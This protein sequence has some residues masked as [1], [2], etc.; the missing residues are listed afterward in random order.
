MTTQQ[1]IKCPKFSGKQEQWG[2]FSKAF[3]DC[4]EKHDLENNARSIE[5]REMNMTYTCMALLR[6]IDGQ[7]I[8]PP[9][10]PVGNSATGNAAQKAAWK[11][12][13]IN[14]HDYKLSENTIKTM[15]RDHL[16]PDSYT[17][18]NGCF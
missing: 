8:D 16:L 14:V 1:Q 10:A 12:A 9:E 11:R 3:I 17:N 6:G 2:T 5:K 18:A 15:L 7:A 13:A 4:L